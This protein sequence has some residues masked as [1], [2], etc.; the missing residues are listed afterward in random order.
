[1]FRYY[2]KLKGNELAWIK[3]LSEDIKIDDKDAI[4]ISQEEYERL[5]KKLFA[6]IE[7][8]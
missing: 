1:M 2:K 6:E 3:R 5:Y 4:E 7:V 8:E